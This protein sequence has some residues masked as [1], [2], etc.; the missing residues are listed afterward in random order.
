MAKAP[1]RESLSIDGPVGAL[2]C[3]LESPAD[4]AT[5]GGAALVCHPHPLHGGTLNNKV[6]HTLAR[7]ALDSGRPALR[8]NFRG[9]GASAGAFD[10][11]VGEVD[12]ASAAA[13]WLQQRFPG[14]LVVGG[15]SFGA[16]VAIE[17]ARRLDP[18]CLISIAPPVARMPRSADWTQPDCPWLL[19]QGDADELVD[20]STVIDFVDG[21]TPGPELT[22]MPDVSHFFHGHLVALRTQVAGFIEE[23][24]P[25]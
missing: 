12:D 24:V 7:A 10:D 16:A 1:L 11:G 23:S 13:D 2:E 20:V 22:V 17:L 15:F 3:L 6:A 9:V 4:G 19:V 8:F 21:L 18:A 25:T 5:V 14:P